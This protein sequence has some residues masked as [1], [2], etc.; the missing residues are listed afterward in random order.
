MK[1][2]ID[3]IGPKAWDWYMRHA[4]RMVLDADAV[5][6]LPDW[7]ASR[8]ATLEVAVAHGLQLPVLPVAAWLGGVA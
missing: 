3:G 8:G 6:V 4:L 5:A 2:Y 7:A 1:I